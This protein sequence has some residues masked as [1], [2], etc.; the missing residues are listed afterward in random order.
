MPM[1]SSTASYLATTLVM[2]ALMMVAMMTPSAAPM[3]RTYSG[4]AKR[5]A[6][7][8]CVIAAFVSG[9]LAV[10]LCFSIAATLLQWTLRSVGLVSGEAIRATPVL[11]GALLILAGAYQFAGLKAACLSS[12]HRPM[13]FLVARWREGAGGAA[14]MGIEHGVICVGCCWAVMLTLFSAGVM[15]L[16]WVGLV[17]VFLLIEKN[18]PMGRAAGRIAGVVMVGSGLWLALRL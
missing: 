1:G 18:L 7:R 9:Y 14:R 10:W 15:N 5:R 2:W 12:C 16:W 17:A 8:A 4:L 3:V 11:G 13:D 6:G